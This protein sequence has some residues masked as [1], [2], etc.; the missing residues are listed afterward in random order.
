MQ[1]RVCPLKEGDRIDHRVF[2]FGTV[3][4]EP[5]AMVAPDLRSPTGTI[6][7]GWMVSV[8][9]DDPEREPSPIASFAL[10]KVSSPESRPFTY[11][12]RQW[13]PL[14]QGW[15]TARKAVEFASTSFRPPPDVEALNQLFVKE[16]EALAAMQ[17]FIQDEID[18]CHP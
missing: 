12:D 16:R 1:E 11:W 13:Q 15:L 3:D 2:G 5:V 6:D 14:V 9:W 10:R 18:G 17:R 4:G 7:A 8:R